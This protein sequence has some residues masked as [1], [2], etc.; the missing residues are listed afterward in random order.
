MF[1]L[2]GRSWLAHE[3]RKLVLYA[4]PYLRLVSM[5]EQH[6]LVLR[7]SSQQGQWCHQVDQLEA[8]HQPYQPTFMHTQHTQHARI[9]SMHSDVASQVPALWLWQGLTAHQHTNTNG[10]MF[11]NVPVPVSAQVQG[12]CVGKLAANLL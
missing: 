12:A 3:G 4:I 6:G 7:G 5:E 11:M 1:I 10:N 9:C 2:K 8:T